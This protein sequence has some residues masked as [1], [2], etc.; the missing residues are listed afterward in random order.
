MRGR[1]G[2]KWQALNIRGRT[3]A[4]QVFPRDGEAMSTVGQWLHDCR[5][6][7][8]DHRAFVGPPTWE[9]SCR[10]CLLEFSVPRPPNRRGLQAGWFIRS[11][12]WVLMC[13]A[14]W[15]LHI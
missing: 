1:G 14:E 10:G 13:G 3:G 4:K 15:L 8:V 12:G 7:L 2:D 5:W 6:R 11:T 9:S